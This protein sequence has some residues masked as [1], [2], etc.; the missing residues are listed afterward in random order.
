MLRNMDVVMSCGAAIG[1]ISVGVQTQEIFHPSG[2]GQ[3]HVQTGRCCAES[4]CVFVHDGSD[5]VVPSTFQRNIPF[6]RVQTFLQQ[7]A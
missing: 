3:S 7:L 4:I 6:D 1:V 5:Q 2:V